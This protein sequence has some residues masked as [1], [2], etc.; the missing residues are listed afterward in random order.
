[1]FCLLHKKIWQ[2]LSKLP[3]D[4]EILYLKT[5]PT[6]TAACA[7]INRLLARWVVL[8]GGGGDFLPCPRGYLAKSGDFFG[9]YK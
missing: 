9:C 6:D 1:M 8:K 4:P 2:Y 5:Y 3:F 7:Q